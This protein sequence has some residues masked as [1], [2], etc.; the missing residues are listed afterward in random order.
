ME[1]DVAIIGAGLSGLAAG[2]RLAHFDKRVVILERHSLP[3]GLNSYYRRN[4]R[5][6]DV[7]LHAVTN[8]CEPN[9]K[10]APFNRLMRQL[11]LRREDLELREQIY[12]EIEFPPACLRFTNDFTEFETS[13]ADTFPDQ[14]DGFR[15]LTRA[16]RERDSLSLEAGFSSARETVGRYIR[17]PLLR[18]MLFCPVM[19]YGNAME[20]DMDFNQFCIMFSALFLEGFWRP[21]Q[22]M[23]HVLDVV[24]KRFRACGGEL[25]LNAGVTSIDCSGGRAGSITLEGGEVVRARAVLSCA[26]YVET[27]RLCKPSP[28]EIDRHPVGRLGYA[29]II[30]ILDCPPLR[31][32][33]GGAIRFFSEREEF[34]YACPPESVDFGSGV[35]CRP[36]NF[37]GMSGGSGENHLR[38]THLADPSF[39]LGLEGDEYRNAKEDVLAEARARLETRFPGISAHVLDTDMFTPATI[40]RYTGHI[41][42]SVYGSPRKH[43]DGVTPVENLF[44]CGTAQGFLGI[45]GAMLSGVSIANLHLL[46]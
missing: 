4:G 26:G 24:T 20:H 30:F 33:P 44:V 39:W 29:E 27:L 1:Y 8:R 28:P 31:F 14:A 32:G 42:G 46:R 43:R 21:R 16:V 3:G 45:V 11:R 10:R 9:D 19:F 7:G 23:R 12:S 18:E 37:A 36:G 17:S 41:N 22:G 6:L 38:L 25:R 15:E 13:V 40:A 2:I 5:F 34:R 35:L